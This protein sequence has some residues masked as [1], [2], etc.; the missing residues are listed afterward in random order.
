MLAKLPQ[1]TEENA[2]SS[3]LAPQQ[4]APQHYIHSA[5]SHNTRLAYQADIRHFERWGGHLPASTDSV[6]RYLHTFASIL[7]PNTLARRLIALKYWHEYQGFSDPTYSPL[8]TKTL[9][10]ITRIHGKPKDKAPP[11]LPEKLLQIVRHLAENTT[12][13]AL[14]DSALLQTG[15]LG[16]FRRSELVQLQVEH[17]D[18]QAQG[19]EILLPSSKTDQTHVGQYCAI[20]YGNDKLCAVRAIQCWLEQANIQAGPVFRRIY[21]NNKIGKTGIAVLSVNHILQRNA[22]SAG[23]ENAKQFSSHSLRRG[24]ATAA[25]RNGVSLQSIMQQG[26]WKQVSTVMEYIEAAGRFENNAADQVL[27]HLEKT[28]SD[29]KTAC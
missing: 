6:L 18:W 16:A 23:L 1:K 19:I 25:S 24:F 7:N 21:R 29:R 12:L 13:Q 27:Q 26:R 10:G 15:F 11:L 17:I 9:S 4:D 8:V 5:T 28:L 3:V 2:L 22:E 20:P 14:R